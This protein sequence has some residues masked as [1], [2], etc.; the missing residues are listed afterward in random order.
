MAKKSVLFAEPLEETQMDKFDKKFRELEV[1]YDVASGDVSNYDSEADILV[2]KD[3]RIDLDFLKKNIRPELVILM[4]P[5]NTNLSENQLSSAGM[6]VETIMSPALLGVAEHAI[7]LM[8]SLIKKLPEV[9]QKTKN[10]NYSDDIEPIVT[11]QNDYTFNWSDVSGMNILYRRTLGLIGIGT[12]GKMVAER[13]KSFGMDVF[14]Y[15]PYRLSEGEEEEMGVSYAPLDDLLQNSDFI[16]LHARVN[17]QT[18]KMINKESLELMKESSYLI[19]TAR[20]KLVDEDDLYKALK[21]DVIA[22]AGLDVFW[23]EPPEKD[24][25]IL[26]LDNVVLT[27]HCAGIYVE[28]AY[29]MEVDFIVKIVEGT[30]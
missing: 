12:I 27:S 3:K 21:N 19:N 2:V 28:D 11:T 25:P 24:N 9:H 20:G 7:L 4:Q 8:L 10:S 6:E 26:D 13:A 18:K 29:E 30:I 23:K 1:D 16:S 17:D 5:G 14:Y 15:D 22:G